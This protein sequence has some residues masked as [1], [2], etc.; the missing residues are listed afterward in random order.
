M[1]ALVRHL[2]SAAKSYT[3]WGH[4]SGAAVLEMLASVT[5]DDRPTFQSRRSRLSK[6]ARPI[7][8][9]QIRTLPERAVVC[10]QQHYQQ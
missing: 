7:L 10:H 1:M 9:N 6:A 5:E 2:R 4:Q 8:K 3:D